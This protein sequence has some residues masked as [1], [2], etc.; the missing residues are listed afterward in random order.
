MTMF[1]RGSL[2]IFLTTP[3]IKKEIIK[4]PRE[5]RE[6]TLIYE[7]RDNKTVR[8]STGKHLFIKEGIT[9][10]AWEPRG[11][12]LICTGKSNRK[13]KGTTGKQIDL[14]RKTSQKCKGSMG[15]HNGL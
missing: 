3:F 4:M 8:G 6:N 10:I 11:N 2:V 5:P 9:N 13:Y 15:K 14:N 1:P 7:G 12:T